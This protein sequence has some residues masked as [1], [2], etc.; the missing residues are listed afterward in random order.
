MGTL[1]LKLYIIFFKICISYDMLALWLSANRVILN[2]QI[3]KRNLEK[4]HQRKMQPIVYVEFSWD[5]FSTMLCS[6]SNQLK[7]NI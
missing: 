1:N 7:L 5:H 4:F 3:R 6:C 2:H